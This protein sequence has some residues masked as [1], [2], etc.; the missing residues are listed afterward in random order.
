MIPRFHA[1]AHRFAS[2]ALMSLGAAAPTALH[3]QAAATPPNSSIISKAD[4]GRILGSPAAPVWLL[5]VSDF[6]C[7]FCRQWHREVWPQVRKEFVATGKV[8]VAF[9]NFPLGIHPNAIPAAEYAM[10]AS[11]EGKFWEYA[12]RAF[13]AQ[14]QWK[15][16]KNATSV[17][18]DILGKLK[19]PAG[20]ETS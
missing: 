1:L 2:L 4:Q 11:S 17:F 15:G 5:V 3:A 12:D 16:L 13:E 18:V 10:C 8:R 14:D 19:L 20:I 7:P 9:V 6:Q